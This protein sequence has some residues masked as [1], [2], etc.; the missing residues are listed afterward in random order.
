MRAVPTGNRK[1]RF[2]DSPHCAGVFV[3]IEVRGPD[4]IRAI[5][6]WVPEAICQEVASLDLTVNRACM[7]VQLCCCFVDFEIAPRCCVIFGMAEIL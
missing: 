2:L 7:S 5:P 4:P 3:S 6:V 1:K